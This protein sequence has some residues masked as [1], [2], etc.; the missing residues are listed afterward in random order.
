[1]RG[2]MRPNTIALPLLLACCLA[3]LLTVPAAAQPKPVYLRSTCVKAN[4]GAGAEYEK[5]HADVYLKLAQYR[6][7]EGAMLRYALSR[8]VLPSGEQS[9]CDYLIS[10]TYPGFPPELTPAITAKN[11]KA[12]GV[13]MTYDAMMARSRSL[14]KQV[15]TRIFVVRASAGTIGPDAYFHVN[16]MKVKDMAAWL[17]LENELWKPIMEARIADKQLTGWT[18][19]TLVLPGGSAQPFNAAT[20]DAYPSWDSMG[21]QKPLGGYVQ[22]VHPG[23]TAAQFNEAGANA[24][25]LLL[26]EVF[27]VVVEA[28]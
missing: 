5:L 20:V 1:M 3:S 13:T 16:R 26:R 4:T 22:K 6:I 15:A 21:T 28:H 23:M 24:R 10:Y 7:K 17:K 2:N 9:E 27:K 11:L 12:A 25:D 18:S 14:A 19:Y 8:A